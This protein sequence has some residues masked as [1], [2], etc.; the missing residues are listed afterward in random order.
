MLRTLLSMSM[1]LA[2]SFLF[3]ACGGGNSSA[4]VSAVTPSASSDNWKLVWADEFDGP[5]LDSNKWTLESGGSG[6]GNNELEYYTAGN[7]LSVA[8]GMLTIE[9]RKENTGGRNYTS[10]RMI[11]KG[12]A[13]WTYGKVEA[14]VRLPYGQGMWPAFWMLGENIDTAGYPGCGEIDIVEMIG[15]KSSGARANNDAIIF[16]SLH[17]PNLDPS[18]T[19]PR[20]TLTASYTNTNSANFSDDFHVFGIEWNA[21]TVRHYVDGTVYQTVDI[22]SH[23]DGFGVFH[24]PFFLVLNLATGGDWPGA[25]DQTTLWPQHMV[26]DWVR[27]YQ[28]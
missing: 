17:R 11:T 25:P 12:K 15:G 24:R 9:A 23:T 27:V 8:N 22:S 21:T 26:V 14:R 1:L 2:V 20:K 5:T 10:T 6:W 3:N 19:T 4:P 28:K 7:N 16:G 13:F 18:P